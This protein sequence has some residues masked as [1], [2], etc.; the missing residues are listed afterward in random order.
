MTRRTILA[1]VIVSL[2]LPVTA[3]AQGIGRGAAE[4]AATGSRAAGP[5][6]GLVG[7]VVG[8][9]VGGAAG[10]VKG[11]LGIPQRTGYVYGRPFHGRCV[12]RRGRRFCR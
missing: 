6:G 8:G 1:A 2:S 12:I 3:E 9:A 7:G 10:A 5:V 11:V 4:G